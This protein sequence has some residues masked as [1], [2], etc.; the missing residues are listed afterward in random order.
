MSKINAREV[1]VREAVLLTGYTRTN[2]YNLIVNQRVAARKVK[3]SGHTGPANWLLNREELLAYSKR[4]RP[5]RPRGP[6]CS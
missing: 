4:K 1:S 3:R 6:V 5:G 2:I